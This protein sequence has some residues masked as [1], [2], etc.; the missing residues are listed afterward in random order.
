MAVDQRKGG[1]RGGIRLG[2]GGGTPLSVRAA[3]SRPRRGSPPRGTTPPAPRFWGAAT[4]NARHSRHGADAAW[5]TVC[6]T[7]PTVAVTLCVTVA[8][9]SGTRRVRPPRSP[10]G[11]AV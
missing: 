11:R 6:V 10:A 4:H 3:A 8:T 5:A 7:R 1:C 2:G 9:A